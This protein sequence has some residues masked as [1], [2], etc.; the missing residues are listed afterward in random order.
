[1]GIA[2]LRFCPSCK[3]QFYLRKG[4]CV[5]LLCKDNYLSQSPNM[6]T[7]R[8]A[9]KTIPGT[10]TARD[11]TF[12]TTK[13]TR[14]IWP[15]TPSWRRKIKRRMMKGPGSQIP[16]RVR[17]PGPVSWSRGGGRVFGGGDSP[18]GGVRERMC[19]GGTCCRHSWRKP[20]IQ[21][22]A[23]KCESRPRFG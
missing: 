14:L 20:E 11:P 23:S 15:W 10:R 2:D 9:A 21:A 5:N 1:M 19:R 13:F 6:R 12:C 18:P 16:L 17:L 22:Y 3:G 7:K 8:A 4:L